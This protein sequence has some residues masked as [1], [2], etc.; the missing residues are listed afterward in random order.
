M[1]IAA[2]TSDSSINYDWE[3]YFREGF[4]WG[5]FGRTKCFYRQLLA[6]SSAAIFEVS[7]LSV[8]VLRLYIQGD[9]WLGFA[10]AMN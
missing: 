7:S 3:A 2:S 8:E 6:D 1:S 4:S 5:S 10:Y 9:G